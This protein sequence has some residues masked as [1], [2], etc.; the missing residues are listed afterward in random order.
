MLHL[1]NCE[2]LGSAPV[3]VFGKNNGPGV[4]KNIKTMENASDKTLLLRGV[5]YNDFRIEPEKKRIGLVAQEVGFIIPEV[6]ITNEQDGL[7]RIEYQNLVGLL[8]NAI[9]E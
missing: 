5:E 9:K 4:R 6:V 8:M 7:K 1:G 3:I 2:V